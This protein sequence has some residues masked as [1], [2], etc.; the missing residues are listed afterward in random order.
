MGFWS[1]VSPFL[2][3]GAVLTGIAG[4]LFQ[5]TSENEPLYAAI[6]GAVAGAIAGAVVGHCFNWYMVKSAQQWE[7]HRHLITSGEKFCD[8]LLRLVEHYWGAHSSTISPD[9]KSGF[10]VEIGTYILLLT[11]F[12]EENFATHP[13]MQETLEQVIDVT[14]NSYPISP[15]KVWRERVGP[16]IEL[17]FAFSNAKQ[18][19]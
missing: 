19:H 13:G 5:F 17:R 6:A 14:N 11:K 18:K 10:A 9:T 4:V 3:A 16:I 12:V 2:L 1:F 7:E 15:P 8:E